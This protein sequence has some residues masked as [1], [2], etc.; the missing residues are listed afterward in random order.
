MVALIEL[1]SDDLDACV[2]LV[3]LDPRVFA[4]AACVEEDPVALLVGLSTRG[5]D[6]HVFVA[7]KRSFCQTCRKCFVFPVQ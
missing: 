6:E 2:L 3:V 5:R 4:D 1:V 7:V